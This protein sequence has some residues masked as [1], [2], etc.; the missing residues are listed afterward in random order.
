MKIGIYSIAIVV[1]CIAFQLIAIPVF[2]LLGT[3]FV[4]GL[5]SIIEGLIFFVG[6]GGAI[7]WGGIVFRKTVKYLN[8]EFQ[9]IE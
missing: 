9:N 5:P 3:D 2:I 7:Y 8:K 6:F 4:K 1:A